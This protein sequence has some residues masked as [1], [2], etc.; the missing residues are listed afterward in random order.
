M[1]LLP[2]SMVEEENFFW[3]TFLDFGNNIHHSGVLL[4]L[5]I[6]VTW[7]IASFERGEGQERA[8]NQVKTWRKLHNHLDFVIQHT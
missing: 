3:Y 2:Q 4:C 1:N 7:K 5:I 8:L 6:L